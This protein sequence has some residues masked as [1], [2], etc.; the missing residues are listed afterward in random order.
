MGAPREDFRV[1]SIPSAAPLA[2]RWLA[3]TMERRAG[4]DRGAGAP[5]AVGPL[6]LRLVGLLAAIKL[7]VHLATAG[8]YGYFRD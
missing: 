2:Y 3:A 5:W 4:P 8:R 1:K 7:A 6:D